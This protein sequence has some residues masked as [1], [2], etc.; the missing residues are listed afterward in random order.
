MDRRPIPRTF[1]TALE[2][3]GDGTAKPGWS[4]PWRIGAK[5][6]DQLMWRGWI[7]RV[8]ERRTGEQTY[9]LTVLGKQALELAR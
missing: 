9:K 6:L 1:R 3:L 7:E 4:F 5:A 8:V 2:H